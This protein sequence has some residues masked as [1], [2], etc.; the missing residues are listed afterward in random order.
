VYTFGSGAFGQLGHGNLENVLAPRP[1]GAE[2]LGLHVVSASAGV[3]RT[4][5]VTTEGQ[6]WA[7]GLNNCGQLGQGGE[8]LDEERREPSPVRITLGGLLD[9]LV[10]RVGGGDAQTFALVES[11]S[12]YSFGSNHVGQLGRETEG[13]ATGM[14]GLV[15]H[16]AL[17]QEAVVGVEAG[18]DSS[19]VFQASGRVLCFWREVG[20]VG[21]VL[22]EPPQ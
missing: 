15:Q 17:E 11:G 6:L 20:G 14:P 22:L 5:V 3:G 1:V 21:R 19:S 7:F 4:L 10:V 16:E 8:G 12:A 18:V 2:L 13:E 9:E